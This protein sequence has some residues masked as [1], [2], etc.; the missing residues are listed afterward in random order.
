MHDQV[1]HGDAV[2]ATINEV[3]DKPDNGISASPRE[4]FFYQ[5]GLPEQLN[6]G[7]QLPMNVTNDINR[8]WWLHRVSLFLVFICWFLLNLTVPALHLFCN[9]G[10]YLPHWRMS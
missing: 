5:V 4:V 7:V 10:L 9:S 1:K 8:G 6:E 2:W 3:T